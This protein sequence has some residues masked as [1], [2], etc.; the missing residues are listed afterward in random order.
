VSLLD[1]K[2]WQRF[3]SRDYRCGCCGESVGGLLDIGYDHPDPWPHGHRQQAG[4]ITLEVGQDRLNS[5]LCALGDDRFIR[6]VLPIPII[7]T[8]ETFRFGPWASLKLE[9]FDLYVQ[10]WE[11]DDYSGIDGFFGW[12]CN[13]LPGVG[14][15][16]APLPCDIVDLDGVSRPVLW[17]HEGSHQLATMQREGITFDQLLDI[18]EAAGMDIRPHLGDA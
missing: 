2:R 11:K 1:D 13:C 3:M 7:D 16:D 6:C 8:G 15:S 12:L 17:V 14:M 10:A 5:D 9:N 4:V 18:F